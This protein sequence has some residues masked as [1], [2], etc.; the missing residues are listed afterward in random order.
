[1]ALLPLPKEPNPN[2]HSIPGV[3]NGAWGSAKSLPMFERSIATPKAPRAP[4]PERPKRI[5]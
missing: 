2:G 1:M 3:R 5:I 4:A